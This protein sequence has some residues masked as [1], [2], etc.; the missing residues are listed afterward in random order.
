MAKPDVEGGDDD[1]D[2]YDDRDV[3]VLLLAVAVDGDEDDAVDGD[4]GRRR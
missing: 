1:Y 4:A 3:V 2:D